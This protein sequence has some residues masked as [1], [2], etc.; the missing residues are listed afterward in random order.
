MIFMK[1]KKDV[2]NLK[3]LLKSF[4]KHW[5]CLMGVLGVLVVLFQLLSF[6]LTNYTEALCSFL[7]ET[8]ILRI[9]SVLRFF[10]RSESVFHCLSVIGYM[11]CSVTLIALS[12][13]CLFST[14]IIVVFC[15]KCF[16][17]SFKAR[18]AVCDMVSVIRFAR[19]R[20]K[21]FVLFENLLI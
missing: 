1:T 18:V 7:P 3:T 16:L 2:D 6:V 20:Q 5:V 8:T 4:M 13:V 21:L 15:M 12:I 17:H 10:F 11:L 19:H 14:F 9:R